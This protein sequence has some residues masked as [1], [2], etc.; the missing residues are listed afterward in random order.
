[1]H[2]IIYVQAEHLATAVNSKKYRLKASCKDNRIF[3]TDISKRRA[4]CCTYK[5]THTQWTRI[6]SDT[7]LNDWIKWMRV[8]PM[9]LT[10]IPI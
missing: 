4:N 7:R 10:H 9:M 2:F 6:V 5:M 1:M 3:S 8:I